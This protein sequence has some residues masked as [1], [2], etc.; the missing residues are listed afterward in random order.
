MSCVNMSSI[1]NIIIDVNA[2][3]QLDLIF[4]CVADLTLTIL[5]GSGSNET[6]KE[7]SNYLL[8]NNI[9]ISQILSG[10]MN[11]DNRVDLIF[12]YEMTGSTQSYFGIVLGN[13]NGTFQIE[14]MQSI[15]M[16]RTPEYTLIVDIDNDQNLDIISA[17]TYDNLQV[18]FGNGNGAFLSP[19]ALHTGDN[20]RRGGL[21]VGDFNN[22][23]YTDIAV[24]NKDDLHI[25]VFLANADRS[26]WLHKWLFT[27]LLASTSS[28]VG[29]DFD[30]DNQ[31]DIFF[32]DIYFS[33]FSLLYRY[34][35]GTFDV[36]EQTA[37]ITETHGSID[38]TAVGDLN[39][40]NLLDIVINLGP[41]YRSSSLNGIYVLFGIG[42]GKYEQ[43][44]IFPRSYEYSGSWIKIIDFNHDN[45]PDIISAD[46]SSGTLDI[47]LNT[48]GCYAH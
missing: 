27:S 33:V 45:C 6:F 5:L 1:K 28:I 21:V 39:G 32:L 31:T 40:D 26:L 10:D 24:L 44:Y 48:C 11:N 13:N 14:N 29:G 19:L 18:F 23:N 43:K 9:L 20:S 8:S 35:N 46:A 17:N 25:H 7:R 34:N 15:V 47:F 3:D 37:N 16:K 4:Y 22:D 38:S 41:V 30:G 36:D 12:I 2:D 42:N